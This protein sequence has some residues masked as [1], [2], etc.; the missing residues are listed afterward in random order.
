[1]TES[2]PQS[3]IQPGS[4]GRAIVGA[5]A[6]LDLS[7]PTACEHWTAR[8]VAAHLAAGAKE[9]ADL[10]KESLAGQPERPTRDFE[11]REAP[12]RDLSDDEL[13][14]RMLEESL[15]KLAGYEALRERTENPAITFTGTRITVDELTNHS[16]SE[17][18]IHHWD[19]VGDN[20]ASDA[21]LAQPDL[22]AHAVKVLNRMP[23]LNESAR[24]LGA[25][26]ASAVAEPIRIV[27]RSPDQ[28]DVVF[29][30]STE[31]GQFELTEQASDH[32]AI[33]TT[34]AANRLLVLWGRRSSNHPIKTAG[35]STILGA[36]PEVFWP[37]AQ[38]WP[39]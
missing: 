24:A 33:V 14:N 3:A 2:A 25:R 5:I 1:M 13:R 29:V 12:F 37:N 26:A 16:R 6:E 15:R 11:A 30:E 23:T 38:P 4:E 7:S 39:G 21:L 18:A 35:D 34:S 28:A 9:I 20:E 19:L 32:A 22:T 31:S 17:A 27:F 10:I 8:H 36:L